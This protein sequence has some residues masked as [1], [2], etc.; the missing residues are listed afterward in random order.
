ML[1]SKL[2]NK[3]LKSRSNKDREAYKIQRNLCVSLLHQNKKDYFETL[4]MKSVTGN[5]MFWET[6][7]SLFSNKSKLS[8]EITLSENEKLIINDH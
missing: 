5:K 4:D 6:V 2:R 1:R 7:A 3:F 8:S